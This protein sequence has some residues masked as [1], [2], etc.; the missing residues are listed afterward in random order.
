MINE[1]LWQ[2]DRLLHLINGVKLP[3]VVGC[4]GQPHVRLNEG[5]ILKLRV[6]DRVSRNVP[7]IASDVLI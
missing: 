4:L 5:D 2:L 3:A 7:A 6:R 1:A